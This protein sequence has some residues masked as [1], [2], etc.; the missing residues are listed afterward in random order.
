[1]TIARILL[2]IVALAAPAGAW[3]QAYQCHAPASIGTVPPIKPD[4]PTVRSPIGGYTFALS[5]APEF[6]HGARDK[7]SMECSGKNGRFGFILHGLWPESNSGPPPQWCAMTP[8]PSPQDYTDNLCMTPTPYL[9]AH[10]WLKHGTCMAK[11]PTAYFA[12]AS[13]LWSQA[14][15]PDV[16]HLSHKNGLTAGDLRDAFIE[17]NP[18]W[19]RES[20]GLQVSRTGGWLREVHVCLDTRYKPRACSAQNFGPANTETLKIWRGL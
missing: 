16:D 12:T 17:A 19:T 3:A 8:L 5:W 7:S 4:G 10:E 1:M 14:K 15:L 2:A 9:I 13:K 20:I 6:C 11:T 18:G